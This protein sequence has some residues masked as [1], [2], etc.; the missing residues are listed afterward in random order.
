MTIR[1]MK[2]TLALS[3]SLA[4]FGAH[5]YNSAD[6]PAM[7]DPTGSFFSNFNGDQVFAFKEF[8]GT[9][10]DEFEIVVACGGVANCITQLD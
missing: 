3:A 6:D 5:A 7:S 10:R 8:F 1:M 2:M 4:M 9:V